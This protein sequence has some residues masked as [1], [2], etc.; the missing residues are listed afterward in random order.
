MKFCSAHWIE[1]NYEFL[2]V[3]I[4]IDWKDS[5]EIAKKKAGRFR[6]NSTIC[7]VHTDGN[8]SKSD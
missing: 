7:S 3:F 6:L 1:P 8:S 5:K 4:E 2:Q